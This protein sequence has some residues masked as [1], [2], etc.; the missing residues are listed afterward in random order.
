[1]IHTNKELYSNIDTFIYLILHLSSDY[2]DIRKQ[3]SKPLETG[4]TYY[5]KHHYARYTE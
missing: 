3:R 5:S 1:M 4:N 2:L